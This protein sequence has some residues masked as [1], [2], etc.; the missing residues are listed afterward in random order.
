MGE[1]NQQ[2]GQDDKQPNELTPGEKDRLVLQE[3]LDAIR[4]GKNIKYKHAWI[5]VHAIKSGIENPIRHTIMF[6]GCDITDV[7]AQRA[8]AVLLRAG[9]TSSSN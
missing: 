3:A 4:G 1:L 2:S 6:R 5:I 8:H 7:D 9:L